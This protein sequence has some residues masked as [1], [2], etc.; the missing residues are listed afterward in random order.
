VGGLDR[1]GSEVRDISWKDLLDP[2]NEIMTTEL[3]HFIRDGYE[4]SEPRS[5]VSV[6]VVRLAVKFFLGL[7]QA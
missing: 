7:A 5:E 1:S 2:N 6:C 3:P 4:E